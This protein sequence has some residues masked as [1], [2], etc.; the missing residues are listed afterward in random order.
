MSS[1]WFLKTLVRLVNFTLFFPSGLK[2][3]SCF[4]ICHLINTEIWSSCT[5]CRY[6]LNLKKDSVQLKHVSI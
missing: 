5:K 1:K 6:K 4:N 2:Y 3:I